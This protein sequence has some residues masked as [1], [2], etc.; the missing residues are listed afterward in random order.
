MQK[1]NDRKSREEFTYDEAFETK[2]QCQDMLSTIVFYKLIGASR[3]FYRQLPPS[4][5]PAAG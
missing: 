5:Y 4:V 2:E 3:P 1:E